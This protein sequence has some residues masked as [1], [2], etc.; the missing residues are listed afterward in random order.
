MDNARMTF[1]AIDVG[2]TRLKWALYECTTARRAGAGAGA[3]FLEN[4]DKLA[5]GAWASCHT[6]TGMLGCVVAG[7]AIKR[8]VEDQMELWERV[9]PA[10]GGGQCRRGWVTNGYDSP[11]AAGRRPLGGHDRCLAPRWPTGRGAP[12]G[13]GDGG[14]RRHGGGH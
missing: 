8:R 2:N 12:D 9:E 5:E 1:L 13:G 10:M 6:P 11:G 4:I 7:D 14:H 3:E